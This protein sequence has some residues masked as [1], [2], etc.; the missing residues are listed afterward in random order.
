MC[1]C[2]CERAGAQKHSVLHRSETLQKQRNILYNYLEFPPI[3]R[4]LDH[5]SPASMCHLN[6]AVLLL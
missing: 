6:L 2:V 3:K 4:S 1:V 5:I